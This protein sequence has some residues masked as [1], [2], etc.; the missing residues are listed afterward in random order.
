M[1]T[2]SSNAASS[3]AMDTSFESR[4]PRNM[5]NVQV[6]VRCRPAS[7]E[8]RA[9]GVHESV[10]CDS[11]GQ[12][13]RVALNKVGEKVFNYDRVYDQMASQRQI[14]DD[15]VEPL[16]QQTL[17]GYN[18]TVL[19]YGQTG[20]GKTHTME[21]DI[22]DAEGM[23]VIPRAMQSI[24]RTL[25]S[26]GDTESYVKASYLEIYNENLTDL[27]SSTSAGD[28]PAN[29]QLRIVED[30]S[31]VG[32][33]VVVHNL[34]EVLVKSW[35]DIR[36]VMKMAMAK[37]KVA[38]TDLNERSSRSHAVFTVTVHSKEY[39]AEG[40][41]LIRVGKINLVDLAGSECVARSGS[42]DIRAR[43]AGNINQSL[44]TLGRVITALV[45]KSPHIAY[46]DS[47]LTRLLQES[48]GGCSLTLMIA[49]VAP[50]VHCLDET[51]S[52]LEYASRAKAIKNKP[53]A[54]QKM[55][56]RV[57]IKEYV[58]EIERLRIELQAARA[59]DGV[60]LPEDQ[61]NQLVLH[62]KSSSLKAQDLEALLE[63]RLSELNEIR[64]AFSQTSSELKK[65]LVELDT[66]R[67]RLAR[68]KDDLKKKE[69]ELEEEK[70]IVEERQAIIDAQATTE[71]RLLLVHDELQDRLRTAKDRIH[72][73]HEKIDRKTSLEKENER[74]VSDLRVNV[75]RKLIELDQTVRDGKSLAFE[76]LGKVQETLER[77]HKFV[78]E[79]SRQ[80]HQTHRDRFLEASQ[81][82]LDR[83]ATGAFKSIDGDMNRVSKEGA[84]NATGF[85]EASTAFGE[86]ERAHEETVSLAR[87]ARE[88]ESE[89][90]RTECIAPLIAEVERSKA[91]SLAF[92]DSLS[93]VS[94]MLQAATTDLVLYYE[95]RMMDMQ[96]KMA[97]MVEA[98]KERS[99]KASNRAAEKMAL[100][101]SAMQDDSDLALR[102]MA[103][104][105]DRERS[106]TSQQ[107]SEH[108]SS[109]RTCHGMVADSNAVW[110]QGE[111]D[112]R[113]ACVRDVRRSESLAEQHAKQVWEDVQER[114]EE[115][116][117]LTRRGRTDANAA[118]SRVENATQTV[119][120][121]LRE[122]ER[123]VHGETKSSKQTLVELHRQAG[124]EDR[125]LDQRG[126]ALLQQTTRDVGFVKDK[127]EEMCS[128]SLVK[129]GDAREVL[130]GFHL[131]EERPTGRT[132]SKLQVFDWTKE[133]PQTSPHA[134]IVD[135]VRRGRSE[136]VGAVI[137]DIED[138]LGS[139]SKSA[140]LPAGRT[141]LGLVER[142]TNVMTSAENGDCD[143]EAMK[144][145]ELRTALKDRGLSV[146]GDKHVLKER[147][148][149]AS[150]GENM[151]GDD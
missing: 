114:S 84:T 71:S 98:E 76:G 83:S 4:P 82:A 137:G 52:T 20:T 39:S 130:D 92:L 87:M 37:R 134:Q 140:R 90:L 51:L 89:T 55:S 120:S 60:Y 132:P 18:T 96:V 78:S 85:G 25:E 12:E 19:A 147:L 113:T 75:E 139:K 68:T 66:E 131:R 11:I 36:K 28:V 32:R 117:A 102:E 5:T 73:L 118:K 67:D 124:E 88:T 21:G 69:Q 41:E 91:S 64:A 121:E 40:E 151:H 148:R 49:T 30:K 142:D 145:Q 26:R 70:K 99:R 101:L 44:L 50:S 22:E 72:G 16:V 108:L 125:E 107:G 103:S 112:L 9:R 74:L 143:V 33:G 43:E 14:Y 1:A 105:M 57:A 65:T 122:R 135:R 136:R 123:A 138:G 6:V 61:Y 45:E 15:M 144:I 23:G 100:I 133:R 129:V 59:K 42:K 46:R 127:M 31:K 115:T 149:R 79:E 106:L 77:F 81:H 62:G 24:F 93:S 29:Q 86:A 97:E 34:E 3:A 110:L 17:R 116:I 7:V 128:G 2:S 80:S 111:S 150:T 146:K 10:H 104:A 95:T 35:D 27:L 126:R 53:M 58:E 13:V 47:K 94:N 119:L 48:L 63:R 8:E 54:N 56:K 141:S 38:A 109:V